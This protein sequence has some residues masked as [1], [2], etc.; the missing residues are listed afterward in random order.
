MKVNQSLLAFIFVIILISCAKEDEIV[1]N[2]QPTPNAANEWLARADSAFNESFS[3]GVVSE[4]L[5]DT[6]FPKSYFPVYP[7]SYWTYR[8]IQKNYQ[9]TGAEYTG[10]MT[11][12]DTTYV[13]ESTAPEYHFL[14]EYDGLDVWPDSIYVPLLNGEPIAGYKSLAYYGYIEYYYYF[15][16]F[17][18]EEVGSNFTEGGYLGPHS[19]Y[20]GPHYT[21]L[22]KTVDANGDSLIVVYG[23]YETT[24]EH[25]WT[26]EIYQ[27]YHKGVGLTLEID[28]RAEINDTLIKKELVDY[29]INN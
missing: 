24:F 4:D 11:G 10:P 13:T 21:V 5:P 8:I 2:V 23:D 19:S 7:G 9:F 6:I 12:I 16:S 1:E 29:Y 22:D 28:Y 15:T 17:L 20:M 27:H 3:S 14:V 26:K 18:R 25:N